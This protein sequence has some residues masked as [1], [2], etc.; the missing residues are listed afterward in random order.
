[1]VAREQGAYVAEVNPDTTGVTDA[2]H[3]S[4]RGPAGEILPALVD[5]VAAR[6]AR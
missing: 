2:V 5:A 4:I 1:V 3:E 6:R